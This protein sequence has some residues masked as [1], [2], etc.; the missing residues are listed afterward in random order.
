[1][2]TKR[3]ISHIYKRQIDETLYKEMLN[4][5]FFSVWSLD[6]AQFKEQLTV[7]NSSGAFVIEARVRVH[8]RMC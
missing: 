3:I 2:A 1:M 5:L 6:V 7:Y 4:P 8:T